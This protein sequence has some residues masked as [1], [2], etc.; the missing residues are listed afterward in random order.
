MVYKI[1]T[2]LINNKLIKHTERMIGEYQYEFRLGRARQ[3]QTHVIHI[4]QR[5]SFY[6]LKRS[7]I[8]EDNEGRNTLVTNRLQIM[9][10]KKLRHYWLMEKHQ[11]HLK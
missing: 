5:Q 9:T 3:Y 8:V 4:L 2:I 1:L 11:R 10:M 6:S 7:L